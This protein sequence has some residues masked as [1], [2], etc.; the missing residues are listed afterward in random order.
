MS[1]IIPRLYKGVCMKTV[2]NSTLKGA[3]PFLPKG[4][5]GVFCRY[6]GWPAALLLAGIFWILA[7]TAV[8]DKSNTFDEIAHLTAGYSYWS[9]NTYAFNPENGNLPQRL[10]ALPLLG[11]TCHFPSMKDPAF[12]QGNVWAAGQKF[13]FELGNPI[14]ELLFRSRCVM[15]LTGAAI[16]LLVFCWSRAIWGLRGA[17]ASSVLA[18]F[19]PTLLANAPL[20]TSDAT[21]ALF[22]LLAV[23][24]A[25]KMLHR[26]SAATILAAAAALGCLALSKMSAPLIVPIFAALFIVRI[27][28]GPRLEIIFFKKKYRLSS[29]LHQFSVLACS[30]CIACLLAVLIIWAAFGCTFKAGQSQHLWQQIATRQEMAPRLAA[31]AHEQKLL[32]EPYLFGFA[33]AMIASE[34]RVAFLNGEYSLKG[35]PHFFAYSF[36]VKTPPSVFLMVMIAALVAARACRRSLKSGR[37]VRIKKAAY[38]TAPLLCFML[39]YGVASLT[40]HLNIGHRHILPLYPALYILTGAVGWWPRSEK[41]ALRWAIPALLC[42]LIAEMLFAWPN[43]I[44][45][46][47]MVAGGPRQA[48]KHLVDSSLDWGQD[49]YGL[50]KWLADKGLDQPG[51]PAVYVS[52][53]GTADIKHAGI[54][55]RVLP[56]FFDQ[57]DPA[58]PLPVLVPG[59]YCIS[60]TMFQCIYIVRA[61][62]PVWSQ[63]YEGMYRDLKRTV[64]QHM[65]N[66]LS[67]EPGSE[68]PDTGLPQKVIEAF[69]QVRFARLCAYLRQREPDYQ[70][71]YSI[72]VFYLNQK[73]IDKALF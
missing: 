54:A 19:C 34:K 6:R 11:L 5:S 23:A 14:R 32:P 36:L 24:T 17:V 69:R 35:W 57:P 43:Y 37:F 71:G 39:I 72:L 68:N 38:T 45:Y 25:W 48:Y 67:L 9:T 7:V 4:L 66:P 20:V 52:Y 60:A 30:M 27:I 49:L 44:A 15:A 50:K 73:D 2:A 58:D 40:T 16:V 22:F 1:P 41:R 47:N 42:L 55:A 10:G 21:G 65:A 28:F 62:G 31:W 53:F 56:G 63:N 18:A 12:I 13:F 26:V 8:K 64:E 3:V 70:V 29:R 59:I 51:A 33:Y 46:F 61:P